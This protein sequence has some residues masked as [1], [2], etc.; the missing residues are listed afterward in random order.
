MFP[1]TVPEFSMFYK[2]LACIFPC[3]MQKGQAISTRE[4]GPNLYIWS[5]SVSGS[6]STRG[7]NCCFTAT[8]IRSW[9]ID[10][11]WQIFK[12]FKHEIEKKSLKSIVELRQYAWDCQ[13]PRRRE[14]S[15]ERPKSAPYLRLK[16]NKRTS[17]CQVFSSTV[18]V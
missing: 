16:N 5:E 11:A 15:R 4:F 18:P 1:C 14:T 7:P 12:Q 13:Y 10:N 3:S 2:K 8:P 6:N 17:K 9:T